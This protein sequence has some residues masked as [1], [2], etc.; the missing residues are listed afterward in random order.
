M[1]HSVISGIGHETDYTISDFTSDLRAPT[2]TAAAE[3]A[4]PSLMELK[5]DISKLQARL[6]R[7]MNSLY[8]AYKRSL[9]EIKNNIVFRKPMQ[10][11]EEKE[12]YLDRLSEEMLF[13]TKRIYRIKAS[14]LNELN[15]HLQHKSPARRLQE[16]NSIKQNL[17]D[18]MTREQHQ[19][20]Y[21]K[22]QKLYTLI[23]KLALLNPLEIMKRGFAIAY[24]ENEK[25]LKS[26][27]SVHVDEQISLKL[28]DGTLSCSV[29]KV[30]RE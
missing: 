23:E 18:H 16:L 7:E 20:I 3:L 25:L 4:V 8:I 12:Q 21:M 1:Q 11:L 15:I 28:I 17:I 2:P 13:H 14:E 10:M 30:G 29:E 22:R 5:N 9:K 24:D 6:T 27:K 26:V 19:I